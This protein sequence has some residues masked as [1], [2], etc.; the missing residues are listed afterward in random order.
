[1]S[2][3]IDLRDLARSEL[4]LTDTDI[5]D[6]NASTLF[7]AILNIYSRFRGEKS[8]REITYTTDEQ[9][10][11]LESGEDHVLYVFW[12]DTYPDSLSDTTV[13]AD[14]QAE[15]YHNPALVLVDKCKQRLEENMADEVEQPWHDYYKLVGEIDTHKLH[16]GIA[17]TTNIVIET[18][19]NFTQ[20]DYPQTDEE[21]LKIGL[22]MKFREYQLGIAQVKSQG[23]IT[24][25]IAG[26]TAEIKR[27]RKD[28]YSSLQT[29]SAG[30]S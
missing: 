17:P 9:E 2:R 27:L 19:K 14:I 15:R 26:M 28:F 12:N 20:A 3:Y 30:R 29:V 11:T 21:I 23:D 5:S 25:D 16:I 6:A 4:H 7:D 1:M 18:R 13:S 8:T 24:F 10:Y 22:K